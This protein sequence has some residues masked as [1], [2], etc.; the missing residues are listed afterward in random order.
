VTGLSSSEWLG[1]PVQD[2]YE[3]VERL[4]SGAMAVVYRARDRKLGRDVALKVLVAG[5]ATPAGV[6]R[7]RRE[8]AALARLSHPNIVTILDII[9]QP[10]G[11]ILELVPGEPL[12]ELLR[13]EGADLPALVAL[14]EKVAR[15]VHHAHGQGILH[16]D[17]KPANI[18]VSPL[19]EPKVVDFGIAQ[20]AGDL[21]LTKTGGLVGTVAYMAPEQAAGEKRMDARTEVYAL[22]AILYE[23]LAG[24]TPFQGDTV[25]VLCRIAS[26]VP[27]PPHRV[28]PKV[29]RELSAIALRALEKE[30]GRRFQ[31]AADF[32]D[33][34][35]RA[36]AAPG[37]V[38]RPRSSQRLVV[39][40]VVAVLA[41]GGG[42]ALLALRGR[43]AAPAPPG[44][45]PVARPRPAAPLSAVELE[46]RARKALAAHDPAAARADAT[47]ALE[48]DPTLAR[49]WATRGWARGHAPSYDW[50]GEIADG[51]RAIELD[52][53]LAAGWYV[54]AHGRSFKGEGG[55]SD[56]WPRALADA[57]KAVE[58]DRTLA[59]AWETRGW[60]RIASGDW[61]G[62]LAD[63]TTA[64]ELDPTLGH[65]W[66][67]RGSILLFGAHP[68]IESAILAFSR[69]VELIPEAAWIWSNRGIAR[70]RN[71]DLSGA[72]EDLTRAIAIEPKKA[73][74][75]SVRAKMYVE[76]HQLDEAIS[77][78]ERYLELAPAGSQGAKAARSTLER[79]R[80][81]RGR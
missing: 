39:G 10:A 61:E 17:L 67:N 79:L 64:V 19:L 29:P 77:D 13:R 51:T 40:A 24:R 15:A 70:S 47:K 38:A 44:P 60:S 27:E 23:I 81:E 6:A 35:R 73:D 56:E 46:A 3:T 48:L 72:V 25:E 1:A 32:A 34:L 65:A 5:A 14:L 59:A 78:L 9:E 42:L 7:F 20:L 68:D 28:N 41:A 54:R 2:R 26:V 16:R 8:A 12:T 80:G 76:L 50:D 45:A 55:A 69:A 57:T 11:L 66:A 22:G 31:S 43:D 18:L 30:P 62:G 74:H 75:L 63:S 4:G 49:A 53:A 52:P 71:G 37:V 21:S 58:L 36:L 33:A